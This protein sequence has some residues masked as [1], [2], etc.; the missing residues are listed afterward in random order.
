MIFVILGVLILT[1]SFVIALVSLLREQKP[2]VASEDITDTVEPVN[3][4]TEPKDPQNK[5]LAKLEGEVKTLE[6][7]Q[8]EEVSRPAVSDDETGPSSQKF[9]WEEEEKAKVKDET[10]DLGK[11]PVISGNLK[12]AGEFSLKDIPKKEE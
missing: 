8:K 2:Q 7:N 12:V 4:Q 1:F 3:S 6:A 10:P 11:A 9:F 5:I